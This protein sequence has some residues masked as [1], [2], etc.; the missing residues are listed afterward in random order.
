MKERTNRG[1]KKF[2]MI[3]H[4]LHFSLPKNNKGLQ[5]FQSTCRQGVTWTLASTDAAIT[6]M[7]FFFFLTFIGDSEW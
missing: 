6:N 5:E 4:I 3:I 2:E 1:C 7:L